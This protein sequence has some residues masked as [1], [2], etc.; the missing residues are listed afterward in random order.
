MARRDLDKHAEDGWRRH[1][2]ALSGAVGGLTRRLERSEEGAAAARRRA[3]AAEEAL[4]VRVRECEEAVA[5]LEGRPH[6][7]Q[8]LRGAG[9]AAGELKR[10]FASA[11][12]FAAGFSLEELRHAGFEVTDLAANPGDGGAGGGGGG[13]N[14]S[15]P[16]LRAVGFKASE[17]RRSGCFRLEELKGASN[18][19]L[20]SE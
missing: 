18:H 13:V 3:A 15:V 2:A 9:F 4:A 6:Q 20:G 7:L 11:E 5:A 8:V 17:L 1:L 14:A 19:W 16:E 12:L 10:G